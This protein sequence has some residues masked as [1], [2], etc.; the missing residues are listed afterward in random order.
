MYNI[1]EGRE[2]FH[3]KGRDNGY[4]LT[5]GNFRVYISGNTEDVPEMRSLQNMDLAFVCMNV[6]FTMDVKAAASA[7]VEYAPTYVYPYHCRGRDNG[8]QDPAECAALLTDGITAKVGGW[9][10]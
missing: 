4:V 6:P 3:P 7:V 2:N 8:P 10:S 5:L 9:Y 1:T